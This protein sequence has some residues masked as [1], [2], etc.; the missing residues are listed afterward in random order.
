MSNWCMGCSR[1]RCRIFVASHPGPISL[2]HVDCDL[3]SS[4]R[5]IF[6]ALGDRLIP[7]SVIVFD[8]YF[9]YT[10][11]RQHEYK[12]FQEYLAS[13]ERRYEYLSLVPQHQQVCVRI[14]G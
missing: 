6:A 1:T 4:T 8:E 13:S 3:Y 9:N 14:T 12:A 11:W 10:G 7:G 5:T 2:L